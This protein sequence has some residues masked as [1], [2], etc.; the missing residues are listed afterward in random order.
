MTPALQSN[1]LRLQRHL[2]I[3]VNA[4]HFR[5]EF[6]QWRE[7]EERCDDPCCTRPLVSTLDFMS[8]SSCPMDKLTQR[9]NKTHTERVHLD[10]PPS[11]HG[12]IRRVQGRRRPRA[13]RVRN[14]PSVRAQMRRPAM[15]QPMARRA[16]DF[17]FLIGIGD[18]VRTRVEWVAFDAALDEPYRSRA[19]GL[20]RLRRLRG[21]DNGNRGCSMLRRARSRRG[22]RALR[23]EW[24]FRGPSAGNIQWRGHEVEIEDA[25]VG[26]SR[27][28]GGRPAHVH[29]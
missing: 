5:C 16:D 2:D 8:T 1:Q 15:A 13:A 26:C 28:C 27:A 9:E 21:G 29:D 19:L 3:V 7:G 14:P 20:R 17:T 25:G 11:K 12:F 18:P 24:A 6:R 23:R 22:R 10:I 4:R